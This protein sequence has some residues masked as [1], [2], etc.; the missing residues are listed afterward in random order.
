MLFLAHESPTSPLTGGSLLGVSSVGGEGGGGNTGALQ[1]GL[2]RYDLNAP[3][4]YWGWL[5]LSDLHQGRKSRGLGRAVSGER[6]QEGASCGD[7]GKQAGGLHLWAKLP[8]VGWLVAPFLGSWQGGLYRAAACLAFCSGAALA[9]SGC[10]TVAPQRGGVAT[11]GKAIMAPFKAVGDAV[12]TP[13]TANSKPL[14]AS[15]AGEVASITQPDNPGQ[16]SSQNY[17]TVTE[18]TLTFSEPTRI[19]ESVNLPN[20]GFQTR[21]IHVPAGS[22]KESKQTQKVGQ[23]IG[24]AQKDN[25]RETFAILSSLRWVQGIGILCI[26]AA[27]FGYAHPI[28]RKLAG[29]KDTALVLGGVGALMVI[30]PALW[31]QYSDYFVGALLIA[32]AYWFVSR[33]KYKEAKLDALTETPS[34]TP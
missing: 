28:G 10:S 15:G 9:L 8:V 33:M 3:R 26:L 23:V 11:I 1:G 29:G 14:E 34:K 25:T 17:E 19:T 20:G 21:T 16:Q 32:G 24:A 30:G 4:P 22:K 5:L 6:R 27:V 31:A 2:P 7:G 18:D 12:K 13:I